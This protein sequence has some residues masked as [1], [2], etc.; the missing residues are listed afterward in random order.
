MNK[1]K[2]TFLKIFIIVIS[3]LIFVFSIFYD[4]A[5]SNINFPFLTSV[6]FLVFIGYR[7]LSPYLR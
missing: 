7:L 6:C 2:K 5:L 4:I 3:F 1:T